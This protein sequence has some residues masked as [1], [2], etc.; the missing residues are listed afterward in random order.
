MRSL[1]VQKRSLAAFMVIFLLSASA[2]SSENKADG[3]SA[4][5]PPAP[6]VDVFQVPAA[7][8]IPVTLEYPARVK[9]VSSITIVARVAGTLQKKFFT[10]GQFVAKGDLLYKIEP[11]I[12]AAEVANATAQ[13]GQATAQWNN[14]EREW[15]RIKNLYENKVVSEQDRDAAFSACEVAK[16]AL[17]GSE[18][19]LRQAEIDLSY[20][21]VRAT[22]SG[23]TG[24]EMV[25]V[26]NMVNPGTQLVTL[27]QMD[28]VHVEFSLPDLAAL[29]TKYKVREGSWAT[30]GKHLRAR[31][32]TETGM[33]DRPGRIDFLDS[34][35]DV[36]T[37][38]VKIRAVFA[39]PEN[40]VLPGQFVRIVTEGLRRAN[41]LMVPQQAVIQNP[42]G[43]MVFVVN[44][45][46][47]SMRPVVAG[48]AVGDNVIIEKGLKPGEL[49]VVNNFFKI[50][51]NGPVQTDKIINKGA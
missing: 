36:K 17:A 7:K 28:P 35:I 2:C 11:D 41:V 30:I 8:D 5:A 9:S 50:R 34:Q 42:E 16:A 46:K 15:K 25:D 6:V 40:E 21:D 22:G 39:N 1:G 13:V 43:A 37:A 20:T 29:K 10:E 45:G 19:R 31:L 33:Y 49:V 38:T 3:Q 47:A 14:A 27:T 23:A 24:L 12:Y 51:P 26:G 44:A 48:D 32:V 18:A 4:V